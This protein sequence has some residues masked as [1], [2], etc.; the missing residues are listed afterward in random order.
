MLALQS[1]PT[2]LPPRPH[3]E[4]K[5]GVES[6]AVAS[7][8]RVLFAANRAKLLLTYLLF[9]LENFLR[10]SQPLVLGLSASI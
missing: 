7:P 5:I 8:L 10:L 6:A 4:P 1:T 2:I 3:A 9:N